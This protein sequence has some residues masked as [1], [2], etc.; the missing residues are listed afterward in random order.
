MKYDIVIIGGGIVGLAVAF[1]LKTIKPVLKIAL[2]EKEP[3]LAQHQSSHNSGVIH[4]GIYYK[5][6]SLKSQLCQ[7]GYNALIDFIT[8]H[9]IPFRKCGKL[10]VSRNE[11]ENDVLEKLYQNGLGNNLSQIKK[12]SSGEICEYEPHVHGKSAIFVPYTGVVNF[13]EVAQKYAELFMYK[14]GQI[15]LSE[16]VVEINSSHGVSTVI[17]KTHEFSAKYVITCGG[18]FSDKLVALSKVR[19]AFRI[20]PFRGE[21]FQIKKEKDYL[22]RSLIYPVPNAQLPFLGVH[23]TRTI[24]GRV[25]VGPNAIWASKREGYRKTDFNLQE[26]IR[27]IFWPGFLRLSKHYWKYGLQ[28]YYHSLFKIAFVKTLQNYIPEIQSEDLVPATSGVRAQACDQKGNLIED[29]L[30][31]QE[32]NFLHVANAPS[33]AATTSLAIGDRVADLVM[34]YFGQ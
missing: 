12:I 24:D 31:F 5:P 8:L 25:L 21:Y 13:R 1:K 2:L 23:F 19:S 17:T 33:P 15:F 10:I 32:R 22:V 9:G 11:Q 18:L 30:I 3:G 20:L 16:Y 34:R 14:D 6:G 28:E 7:R 26:F 27:T 29:F 4:S